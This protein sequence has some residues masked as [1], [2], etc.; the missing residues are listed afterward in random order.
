MEFNQGFGALRIRDLQGGDAQCFGI[1][2]LIIPS[3][4]LDALG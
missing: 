4:C 2:G 3:S 1:L